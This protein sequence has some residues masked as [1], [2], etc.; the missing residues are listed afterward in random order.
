MRGGAEYTQ[1]K[2]GSTAS[3][4]VDM[5]GDV[6]QKRVK[7]R[8]NARNTVPLCRAIPLFTHFGAENNTSIGLIGSV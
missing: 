6:T 8:E 7:K 3:R 1:V 2:L 5:Y 4:D